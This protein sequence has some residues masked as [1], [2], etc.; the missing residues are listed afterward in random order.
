MYREGPVWRTRPETRILDL[1]GKGASPS[2]NSG[3]RSPPGPCIVKSRSHLYTGPWVYLHSSYPTTSPV[4]ISM[5][6]EHYYSLLNHT[7]YG[8]PNGHSPHPSTVGFYNGLHAFEHIAL[9]E[10]I[11]TPLSAEHTVVYS[12]SD[13]PQ[14]LPTIHSANPPLSPTSQGNTPL[15]GIEDI[16]TY[17]FQF[18]VSTLASCS[19]TVSHLTLISGHPPVLCRKGHPNRQS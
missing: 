7:V 4:S 5:D 18:C 9:A 10:P 19:I 3:H 6:L 11:T 2:R 15:S 8:S 12:S 14:V 1:Q 16:E 17:L 13:L